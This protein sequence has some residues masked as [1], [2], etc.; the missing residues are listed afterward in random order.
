MKQFLSETISFPYHIANC[1]SEM[2]YE[3]EEDML[4]CNTQESIMKTVLF[5]P[6]L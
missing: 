3:H 2:K 5:A 6:K 1:F 4:V